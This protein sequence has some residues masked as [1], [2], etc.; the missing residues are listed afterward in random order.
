[1]IVEFGSSNINYDVMRRRRVRAK[2]RAA[3]GGYGDDIVPD[4]DEVRRLIVIGIVSG[5]STWLVTR[6]LNF[7]FFKGAA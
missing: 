1:M 6:A 2:Q 4:S 7:V 5:V 3:L